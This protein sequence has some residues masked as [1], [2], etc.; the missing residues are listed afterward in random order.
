M[1]PRLFLARRLLPSLLLLAGAMPLAAQ[2]LPADPAPS[3]P[4]PP[5]LTRPPRP[6]TQLP[7]PGISLARGMEALPGGGWRLTGALARGRPDAAAR[8]SLA[9]IARWLAQSTT[10]RV[11]VTAQVAEPQD[12]LSVARRE[13]LARGLAIRQVL[14]EAGLD[15]TRIDVRPLGRTAE[16]RDAIELLPPGQG[17][18]GD[19]QQRERQSGARQP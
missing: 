15:G 17:R 8:G 4:S 13:S 9:E 10:G 3:A 16:A 6:A 7:Q 18:R 5:D 1:L 2:P 12:D 19:N 11:T 14:E